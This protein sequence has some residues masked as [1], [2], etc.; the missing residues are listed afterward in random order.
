MCK[1]LESILRDKISN[2]LMEHNAITVHQNGFV[3]G[4]SC[5]TNLLQSLKDWT[6]SLDNGHE[7][8]VVFLDFQKAFDTGVTIASFI[9]L[10]HAVSTIKC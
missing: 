1:V 3:Q 6:F 9:N 8:D 4:R 10:P 5:L 2:F 7:V